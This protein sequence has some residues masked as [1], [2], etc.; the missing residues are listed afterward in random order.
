MTD[1]ATPSLT[2]TEAARAAGVSRSTVRRRLDAGDFPGAWREEERPYRW[3]VPVPELLAAGI[4]VQAPNRQDAPEEEPAGETLADLRAALA[5]E[6]ERRAA[7][8]A[9]AEERAARVEDLRA[10]LRQLE[11]RTAAV[12]PPARR[13]LLARVLRGE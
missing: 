3:R 5:V 13:G 10:S 11:A 7:A 12:A 8:E 4:D 2:L 1:P 6:R 9:L